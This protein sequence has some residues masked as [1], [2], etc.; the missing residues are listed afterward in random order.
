MT[1]YL[2]IYE[3]GGEGWSAY[4]PDLPGCY[5]VGETREHVEKLMTE[6]VP[7][8]IEGLREAGQPVPEPVNVPGYVAV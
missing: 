2:V 3:N 4:S 5:A 7:F 1:E 8:H 6:A